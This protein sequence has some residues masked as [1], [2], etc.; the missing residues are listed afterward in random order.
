MP[1]VLEVVTYPLRGQDKKG[2]AFAR[3]K[4]ELVADAARTYS[5]PRFHVDLLKLEFPAN[6]KYAEEFQGASF[7]AGRAVYGL[8]EVRS[9]CREVD[10]AAAVPW[11]ILSAGVDSDEFIEDV[12]LANEA[13]ASGFLC[14]RA[15]WKR[16]VDAFPDDRACVRMRRTKVAGISAEFSPPITPQCRGTGM[17]ASPNMSRI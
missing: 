6:L 14:G 15:V 13:G 11:V 17:P 5:E 16:I 2:E 3:L 10:S 4:P 7:A 8:D 1:F 12:R 9:A